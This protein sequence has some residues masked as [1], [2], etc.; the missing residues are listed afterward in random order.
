MASTIFKA[1]YSGVPVY[2]MPTKGVAVS[3]KPPRDAIKKTR[4]DA[5]NPFVFYVTGYASP[6]RLVDERNS[7]I[8]VRFCPPPLL[9]S[10]A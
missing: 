7:D 4:L 8:K 6:R 2:E 1:T 10:R 3:P 9:L 5:L